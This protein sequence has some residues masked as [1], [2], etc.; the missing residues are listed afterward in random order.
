[1]DATDV[2]ISVRAQMPRQITKRQRL[3]MIYIEF[4]FISSENKSIELIQA[5]YKLTIIN[6]ML[7]SIQIYFIW[8]KSKRYRIQ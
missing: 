4:H 2:N 7:H 1:M 5:I 6:V 8:T 3:I